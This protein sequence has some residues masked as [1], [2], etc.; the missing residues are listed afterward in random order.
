MQ[1]YGAKKNTNIMCYIAAFLY[2]FV[3]IRLFIC[4]SDGLF[5]CFPL[6]R[7]YAPTLLRSRSYVFVS[8]TFTKHP[9]FYMK[10]F[11]LVNIICQYSLLPI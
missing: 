11:Y 2:V 4:L 5:D 8:V 9:I 7:S 3:S 6:S 10:I 1:F